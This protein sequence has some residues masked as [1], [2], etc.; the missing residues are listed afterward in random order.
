MI[1]KNVGVIDPTCID[2]YI[3]VGGY[4]ALA[5]GSHDDDARVR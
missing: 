3:A 5:Q 4:E 1:L 2:E